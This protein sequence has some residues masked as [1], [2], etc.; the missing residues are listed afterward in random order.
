MTRSLL[1]KAYEIRNSDSEKSFKLYTQ[2]KNQAKK[3]GD[4]DGIAQALSGI[5]FYYIQTGKYDRAASALFEAEKLFESSQT[6]EGEDTWHYNSGILQIRLGNFEDAL[7]HILQ[8]LELRKAKGTNSEIANCHFQLAYICKRFNDYKTALNHSQES[9]NLQHREKNLLGEAASL[10]VQGSIY[11]ESGDY[12]AAKE[13]L[14]KCTAIHKNLSDP[15]GLGAALYYSAKLNYKTQQYQQA[16]SYAKQGL[17]LAISNKDKTGEVQLLETLGRA[18]AEWNKKEKALST[19]TKGLDIAGTHGINSVVYQLHDALAATYSK[20]GEYDK[21]YHHLTHHYKIKEQVL[22]EDIRSKINNL[23][24]VQK[25][26]IAAKETEIHRLKNIE[27][28]SA[29][30]QI[31]QK[32]K[33]IMDSIKY[34]K[35]IQTAILPSNTTITRLLPDSFVLYKPKD[36]VAGDFYWLE[37]ISSIEGGLKVGDHHPTNSPQG[38]NLVLFAAADCTGHGVPGAMVSVVCH[39][40]LNRS[41][42]EHGLTDPGKILDKTREIIITEFEKSDEDVKDGMDI[43]LCSLN[44]NSLLYAG[45]HN[46]LWIVREG[47]LIEI[48]ADKQP[49]GKF[50]SSQSF[51]THAFELKKGDTI[52]IFSDGYVDQFGGE[53]GKKFKTK[54]LRELLLS[55]Q[56]KPMEE[57]QQMIDD[58]YENWKGKHEQVDDVCIIGVR[59]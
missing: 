2:V 33:D 24:L 8:S 7:N 11:I 17:K 42:R 25:M 18:Y 16:E 37:S 44:G 21:A 6:K 45:A 4:T 51:T 19:L 59:I 57:Q 55:V 50:D 20:A 15:R 27:L 10:M 26:E 53:K 43:A 3:T 28:K 35:R 58:A 40:A 54:A 52:Y 31:E 22:N 5:S 36:I 32:N 46:P 56:H 48:K 1:A 12:T 30:E 41:V 38:E 39:N 13:S 14:E 9:Y 23:Q 29:N 47:E 34:A 49:I